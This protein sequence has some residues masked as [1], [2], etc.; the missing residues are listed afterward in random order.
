MSLQAHRDYIMMA[1]IVQH[2]VEGL[3]VQAEDG[4]WLAV[5]PEPGTLT[6]VAGDMFADAERLSVLFGCRGKDGVLLSAMDELVDDDDHPLVYHPCTNDGYAEFR[7]SDEGGKCSDPLKAFC[8]VEKD[9]Q[10][11]E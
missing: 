7:F 10:P 6:F 2:E 11:K 4:S 9:G 5:P 1:A 3:Q 8:G